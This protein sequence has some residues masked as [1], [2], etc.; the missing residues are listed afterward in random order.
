MSI[1]TTVLS[2]ALVVGIFAG[3]FFSPS[4]EALIGIVAGA[5]FL[6]Y[7]ASR[8]WRNPEGFANKAKAKAKRNKNG[9]K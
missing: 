1:L 9:K 8:Y 5:S 4:P 3:L 2:I 7:G 6:L